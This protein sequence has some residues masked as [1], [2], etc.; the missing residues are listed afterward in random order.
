MRH[1]LKSF[2]LIILAAAVTPPAHSGEL[3]VDLADYRLDRLYFPAGEEARIYEH[4]RFVIVRGDDSIY[5]GRIQHAW[6]GVATSGLT[7]RFF[8]SL[9]FDSLQAVIETAEI[10]TASAIVIG[11]DLIGL[12]LLPEKTASERVRIREYKDRE[13]MLED[14]HS[15]L[16]DGMV[17]FEALSPRPE[18]VTTISRPAPWLVV[19]IP[20]V[21]RE[22]NFQGQ[23]TTSLYYRFDRDRLSFSFDGDQPAMTNRFEADLT[24]DR[25]RERLYRYDPARGRKLFEQMTFKPTSLAFHSSHPALDDLTHYF[26]DIV[27]RDRCRVELVDNSHSADIRIAFSPTSHSLPSVTIYSMFHQLVVDSAADMDSGEQ[28]R[29]IAAELSYVESQ[30]QLD[31]YY[32]HLRNAG[33]I[34]IEE[35]GLFP[36]FRPTVFLTTHRRLQGFGFND[37]DQI[38]LSSGIMLVLPRPDEEVTP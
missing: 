15:D 2:S 12:S 30:T 29:R 31:E 17:S 19:M 14:F 20:H 33:R 4:A 23:M 10:D 28:V 35:L 6:Q 22:V 26:A 34:M 21:G 13:S 3:R 7:D 8:D 27:S 32:R 36:L 1:I 9:D 37:D 38:D 18:G 24:D 16:L 11:S 5:S 25:P